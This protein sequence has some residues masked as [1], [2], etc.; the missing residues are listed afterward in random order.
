MAEQTVDVWG[1]LWLP[2][3]HDCI[4][5]FAEV[6]AIV[7]VQGLQHCRLE[8]FLLSECLR[9][10]AVVLSLPLLQSLDQN[11]GE[12]RVHLLLLSHSSKVESIAEFKQLWEGI[13]HAEISLVDI[14]DVLLLDDRLFFLENSQVGKHTIL[15]EDDK[16]NVCVATE[17][18]QLHGLC[19]VNIASND[20]RNFLAHLSGVALDEFLNAEVHMITIDIRVHFTKHLSKTFSFVFAK[21]RSGNQEFIAEV[22]SSDFGIVDNREFANCRQNQVL[23]GL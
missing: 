10:C 5:N 12:R 17:V 2:Q 19:L 13:C 1:D 11:H 20:H 21:V 7:F 23:E 8:Q 18:T 3:V 4:V 9:C 22:S 6:H 14:L 16:R 15:A